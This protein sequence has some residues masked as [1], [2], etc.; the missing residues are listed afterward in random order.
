M[1]VIEIKY[2]YIYEIENY[3][4]FELSFLYHIH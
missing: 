4:K 3:F 1:H 2:E